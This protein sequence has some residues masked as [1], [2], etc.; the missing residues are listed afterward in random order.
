MRANL[1]ISVLRVSKNFGTLEFNTINTYDNV[2]M[3]HIEWQ[4]DSINKQ[5]KQSENFSLRY[6]ILNNFIKATF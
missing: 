2:I 6:V 5:N 4:T 1:A 3:E